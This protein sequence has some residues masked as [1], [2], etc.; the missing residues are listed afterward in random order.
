M[1][2]SQHRLS[3]KHNRL[4]HKSLCSLHPAVCSSVSRFSQGVIIDQIHL[5]G[6]ECVQKWK[7]GGIWGGVQRRNGKKVFLHINLQAG[8]LCE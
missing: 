3:S 4:S 6:S 5:G 8:N 2:F 7:I 1:G